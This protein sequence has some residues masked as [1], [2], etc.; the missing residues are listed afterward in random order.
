MCVPP[1]FAFLC[2]NFISGLF[3]E[4]NLVS[5]WVSDGVMLLFLACAHHSERGA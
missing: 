5:K 3:G 1:I 4:D 2:T